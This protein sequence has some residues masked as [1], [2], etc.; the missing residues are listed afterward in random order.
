MYAI[1]THSPPL[2]MIAIEPNLGKVLKI[3]I[4]SDLIG[5][6]MAMVINNRHVFGVLMVQLLRRFILQ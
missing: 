1:G 6:Q 4:I 2:V 3:D 5:R